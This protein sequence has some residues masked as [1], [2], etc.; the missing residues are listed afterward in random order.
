MKKYNSE[1]EFV[2]AIKNGSLNKEYIHSKIVAFVEE[3]NENSLYVNDED[4]KPSVLLNI[5][6]DGYLYK[7]G[8]TIMP[9]KKGVLKYFYWL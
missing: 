1:R 7:A 4:T 2:A 6:L 5:E 9:I 8:I 3:N